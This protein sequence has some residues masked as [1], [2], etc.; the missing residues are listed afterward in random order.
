MLVYKY[1]HT[2]FMRKHNS[3]TDYHYIFKWNIF[4]FFLFA[5]EDGITPIGN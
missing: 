1:Q 5:I 4:E 2:S 3:A